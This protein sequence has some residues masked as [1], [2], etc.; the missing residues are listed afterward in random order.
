MAGGGGGIDRIAEEDHLLGDCR[1]Q[2]A[3]E[4]LGAAAAWQHAD[5]DLRHAELRALRHQPQVASDGELA[6]AAVGEAV[7]RGD[8]R[9]IERLDLVVDSLDR[10]EET[11]EPRRARQPDEL[12]DVGAGGERP[13]RSGEDDGADRGIGANRR[14]HRAELAHHLRADRVQPLRPGQAHPADGIFDVEAQGLVHRLTPW[15]VR[16]SRTRFAR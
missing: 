12:G 9:P 11:H 15:S 8:R 14:D 13:S 5:Q 4:A 2:Q 7:D 3:R 10:L 1:R 6:A 16:R